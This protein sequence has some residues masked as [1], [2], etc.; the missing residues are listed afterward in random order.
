M[1]VLLCLLIWSTALHAQ[2]AQPTPAQPEAAQPDAA[3]QAQNET[4]NR[5]QLLYKSIQDRNATLKSLQR[6][7]RAAQTDNEKLHIQE[8]LVAMERDIAKNL[9]TFSQL[10]AGADIQDLFLDRV[11]TFKIEEQVQ[12]ILAPLLRELSELTERPRELDRLRTEIDFKQDRLALANRAIERLEQ[13]LANVTEADLKKQLQSVLREWTE[14]R[15]R[16]DNELQLARYKQEQLIADRRSLSEAL[17]GMLDNFVRNRG[18]NLLYAVGAF[19]G[20]FFVMRGLRRVLLS[21][22]GLSK[23]ESQGFAM[24]LL[25]VGFVILAVA[26]AAF[27]ALVTLYLA[28]DWLLLVI[29]FVLILSAVWSTKQ[30]LGQYWEEIK[31]I[32]NIGSVREGERIVFNGLPWK[33]ERLNYYSTLANPALAGGRLR[34]RLSEL[35][36]KTSRPFAP[37]EPWFP[38][39]KEDWVFL[40]DGTYGKVAQQNPDMVRLWLFGDSFKTYP[41]TAFLGQNP[42]VISQGFLLRVSFG[43]DYKHQA[44]ATAVIPQ[45]LARN[46]EQAIKDAGFAEELRSVSS[47]FAAAGASS[48]DVVLFASFS[49]KVADKYFFFERLMQRVCVETCTREGWNIPFPQLTVHRAQRD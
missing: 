19:L 17:G 5:L 45:T 26:A 46:L 25:D 13:V 18:K 48:L 37:D 20:V 6:E 32:L 47:D 21:L 15:D 31:L 39:R 49:G 34:I 23:R 4:L 33:V 7:L 27:A 36:D 30:G 42:R 40:D 9:E 38:T 29:A 43:V 10:A 12:I 11:E 2:D 44:I 1:L 35:I 22:P 24:R 14:R 8:R 3:Q 16:L 28:E 41:T